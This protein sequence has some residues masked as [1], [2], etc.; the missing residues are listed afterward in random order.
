MPPPLSLFLPRGVGPA[1]P[2]A[3]HNQ[4][5]AGQTRVRAHASQGDECASPSR[6][7]RLPPKPRIA[8]SSPP[9]TRCVRQTGSR[10]LSTRLA[11]LACCC[12]TPGP[13]APGPWPLR[14]A[15]SSDVHGLGPV[16][17][18]RKAIV[19]P[20]SSRRGASAASA[21]T[22]SRARAAAL[23]PSFYEKRDWPAPGE[24][25]PCGDTLA[26]TVYARNCETSAVGG[27][28][29][30]AACDLAVCITSP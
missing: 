12:S 27:R 30:N 18:A 25:A 26:C 6:G 17:V 24:S 8:G 5:D 3:R 28:V 16:L 29:G 1:R 23:D 10:G 20:C 13:A 9:A 14:T 2:V 4:G 7:R 21:G 22:A 19:R 15:S 11:S